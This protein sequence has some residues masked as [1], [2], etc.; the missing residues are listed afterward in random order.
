MVNTLLKISIRIIKI[1]N[2]L[3]EDFYNFT[4]EITTS[5]ERI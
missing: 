3:L 1:R 2:N 5:K 4:R